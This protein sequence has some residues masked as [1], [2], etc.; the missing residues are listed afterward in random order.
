MS[1]RSRF[2]E[3]YVQPRESRYELLEKAAAVQSSTNREYDFKGKAV[4]YSIVVRADLNGY[5]KWAK[6]KKIEERVKLLD[7]F[8]TH[9]A[10]LMQKY[11]G[12]YFRDEGD[13]LVI[14]FSIY[15]D[16]GF[17]NA[18]V[19][20]FCKGIVSKKYGADSLTA[21]CC[22]SGGE[23]AYYQKLHEIGSF[24]WSAEGQPFVNAHRLE[25]AIESKPRIYLFNDD[26]IDSVFSSIVLPTIQWAPSG[27]NTSVWTV[28][29]GEKYQVQG[30]GKNGGWVK[31]AYFE[32]RK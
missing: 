28:S 9:A 25:A 2:Y 24:D 18:D 6:D 1:K 19:R 30:V 10:L 22:V 17:Q 11:N 16:N 31:I 29:Q 26:E 15:F 14:L 7:D 27:S 21:K 32:Y 13:C 12:I 5:S 3:Y 8:F 23:I 20:A 4:Q